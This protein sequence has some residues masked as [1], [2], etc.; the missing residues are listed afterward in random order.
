MLWAIHLFADH[1]QIDLIQGAL[2]TLVA[3]A[4]AYTY[5]QHRRAQGQRPQDAHSN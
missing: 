1:A 4:S 2:G 5:L 3:C